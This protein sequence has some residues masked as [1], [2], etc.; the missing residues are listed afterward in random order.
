MVDKTFMK[1][2]WRHCIG[3]SGT[4]RAIVAI[5]AELGSD[6]RSGHVTLKDLQDLIKRCVAAGHIDKLEFGGLS[7][8]RRRVFPAGLAILTAT[9]ETFDIDIMEFSASALRE[10]VI[11]DMEERTSHIDIRER[12]AHSLATRYAVDVAQAERV[13][14][15]TM[16]LYEQTKKAWGI[17][18]KEFRS[19]LGWAALLH[20]VGLQINSSGVQ[21]HS[22]YILQHVEL[23]G[24]NTEEQQLLST[25]VRFQRKKIRK[26]DLQQFTLFPIPE[27]GHLIV[28][29]RL[30]VLL[31]FKRQPDVVPEFKVKAY[32][33][34]LE[35]ALPDQWLAER[36]VFQA[37]LEREQEHVAVL[38]LTLLFS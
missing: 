27:I 28:L 30:G 20:E 8:D 23:P 25:L 2:N 24:F 9:F 37:Y 1:R 16:V 14:A 7:D 18:K 36:P 3:S 35:L 32:S 22:G 5:V 31:N 13:L 10:G 12:T 4:I 15:T 19:I 34:R 38:G 21:K 26:E 17:G 29:L 11:Y 6:T 33:E